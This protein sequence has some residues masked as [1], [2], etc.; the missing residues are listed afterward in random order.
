[1]S[2]IKPSSRGAPIDKAEGGILLFNDE[3]AS[4]ASEGR[5]ANSKV[6]SKA[7]QPVS[8][9]SL[10]TLSTSK[11]NHVGRLSLETAQRGNQTWKDRLS[12]SPTHFKE[13]QRHESKLPRRV[14]G[15]KTKFQQ[16]HYVPMID[17]E[18]RLEKSCLV[19]KLERPSS[20]VPCHTPKTEP[21]YEQK[22]NFI[23]TLV[24]VN[25]IV[26]Y[27][28]WIFIVFEHDIFLANKQYIRKTESFNTTL[29]IPSQTTSFQEN[30]SEVLPIPHSFEPSEGIAVVYEW[31][32]EEFEESTTSSF[33][34]T[35][36]KESVDEITMPGAFDAETELVDET[37][38]YKYDN[39]ESDEIVTAFAELYS[40]KNAEFTF[41]EI[42][43]T[44]NAFLKFASTTILS[45]ID[46]PDNFEM[47]YLISLFLESADEFEAMS[48][49]L[50]AFV[51]YSITLSDNGGDFSV[52]SENDDSTQEV[53]QAEEHT[54]I[55]DFNEDESAV[56]IDNETAET[57]NAFIEYYA[58][59][60]SNRLEQDSVELIHAFLKFTSNTVLSGIDLPE[61]FEMQYLI[62]MFL[63][64]SDDFESNSSL[65]EAF[66]NF[67]LDPTAAARPLMDE[68]DGKYDS[69]ICSAV[70]EIDLLYIL[71]NIDDFKSTESLE[72]IEFKVH[73][74]ALTLLLPLINIMSTFCRSAMK[75][76][77][78]NVFGLAGISIVALVG[79]M[80]TIS[81]AL[82]NQHPRTAA[83]KNASVSPLNISPNSKVVKK[84]L[85]ATQK[86]SSILDVK[87]VDDEPS[88]ATWKDSNEEGD[89]HDSDTLWNSSETHTHTAEINDGTAIKS[90]K[91]V[92][93]TSRNV[94]PVEASIAFSTRSA[95]RKADAR[96]P[97]QIAL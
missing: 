8:R 24:P 29:V 7:E 93:R 50:D 76:N 28:L 74:K 56:G 88:C 52:K 84:M 42:M 80:F 75:P 60:E 77:Q 15:D 38:D 86:D 21:T 35:Y 65:L 40:T 64:S 34:Q 30:Y 31:S 79:T 49:L 16:T 96:L 72:F 69:N 68:Y 59:L 66:V 89:R 18:R 3:N 23:H 9:L 91:K 82:I 10:S 48:D 63:Q 22:Q 14:S 53:F 36:N 5:S 62:S 13:K 81:L 39:G 94:N 58:S 57:V 1:M 19:S 55:I 85:Q 20:P 41:E 61:E 27:L 51:N 71:Q 78:P 46:L 33:S 95:R 37:D 47:Q 83:F 87:E 32:F 97:M 73:E 4:P 44:V 25:I 67:S 11:V 45:G 17:N 2:P 70:Q 54:P 92:T 6:N 43:H 26:M 90:S 12:L